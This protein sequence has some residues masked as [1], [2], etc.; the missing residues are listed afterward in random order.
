M[1]YIVIPLNAG[2]DPFGNPTDEERELA[3]TLME[4]IKQEFS[5]PPFFNIGIHVV[6]DGALCRRISGR[7]LADQGIKT[8]YA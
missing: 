6:A 8:P 2:G 4:S 3:E 7:V 5:M 1:I